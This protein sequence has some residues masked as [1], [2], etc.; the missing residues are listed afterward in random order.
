LW[1]SARSPPLERQ[2]GS[3][4]Q[5][6]AQRKGQTIAARREV[7]RDEGLPS[8]PRAQPAAAG[9]EEYGGASGNDDCFGAAG[10]HCPAFCSLSRKPGSV[11]PSA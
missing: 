2:K 11:D 1:C 7:K 4:R 10:F 5:E 6:N 3:T 9:R 8:V